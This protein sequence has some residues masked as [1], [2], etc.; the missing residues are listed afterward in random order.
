VPAITKGVAGIGVEPPGAFGA[1]T[2]VIIPDRD[3]SGK[4]VKALMASN[5]TMRLLSAAVIRSREY[6]AVGP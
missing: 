2:G 1:G 6:K 4:N 3:L 5:T